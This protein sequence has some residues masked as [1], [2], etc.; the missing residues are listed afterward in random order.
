[1]RSETAVLS[2]RK[3]LLRCLPILLILLLA[4]ALRLVA[5]ERQPLRGD[6]A[7]SLE[8]WMNAPL[9]VSL[10]EVASLEPIPPAIYG[11]YRLWGLALGQESTWSLRLLPALVNLLGV[12]AVYALG[13]QISHQRF[14]HFAALLWALLPHLLWH[15]QDA[16][17]Y[18]L[19]V[20]F[21]ALALAQGM[22]LVSKRNASRR[23]WLGY[24]LWAGWALFMAYQEIALLLTLAVF[25]SATFHS[26]RKVL[27]R[28]LLVQGALLV[29]IALA[30]LAFQGDLLWGGGYGGN[31]EYV[32]LS[33]ML[34]LPAIL[35]FGEMAPWFAPV[36]LG[37]LLW[38]SCGIS[39]IWLWHNPANCSPVLLS[40]C[41]LFVPV[42]LMA[43]AGLQWQVFH[44]RYVLA[45]AMGWVLWL[46]LLW[47]RLWHRSRLWA[48]CFSVL[49]FFWFS[50]SL[51]Q[52][53]GP[54]RKAVDWAALV[55][56][57]SDALHPEDQIIHPSHDLAFHWLLRQ[58]AVAVSIVNL[59]AGPGQTRSELARELA[60]LSDTQATLWTVGRE[61]QD[62]PNKDYITEWLSSQ[63]Q[64]GLRGEQDGIPY[65][66]YL[67]RLPS[68]IESETMAPTV[69]AFGRPALVE[70][71][72]Y[73]LDAAP[74]ALWLRL[75]WLPVRQSDVPL[76]VFVHLVR[77]GETQP[78]AQAD[79]EPQLAT[80]SWPI[81]EGLREIHMLPTGNLPAGQY[82]LMVGW[83]DP[84]TGKR[85]SAPGGGAFY[86]TSLSLP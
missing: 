21:S 53:Y 22:R 70:L 60:A 44:A 63:R 10:R 71:S 59:P 67:P 40:A 56:W 20:S 42:F 25:V 80:V 34:S 9:S 55:A 26:R 41:L 81:G 68:N 74:D 76:K 23:D 82:D 11:A 18:A 28:F 62:W 58:E 72:G 29:L 7:F 8:N 2:L 15:A 64:P 14:A 4:A 38:A 3:P 33:G 5:L 61:Y 52:Y 30:F 45:S 50:F 13:K 65:A 16:R 6:E 39:L 77:A 31:L 86:L 51:L 36:A 12:A 19:W 35:I 85:L 48:V 32:S 79:Q 54:Y 17:N 1:M 49:I 84:A 69:A 66:A 46:A 43:V 27:Q 75:F 83:Y 37:A 24:A 57:L 78:R 47:D 73:L